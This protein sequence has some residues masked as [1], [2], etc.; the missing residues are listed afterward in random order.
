MCGFQP[1]SSENVLGLRNSVPGITTDASTH[2]IRDRR[3]IATRSRQ[4]EGSRCDSRQWHPCNLSVS[5]GLE[6]NLYISSLKKGLRGKAVAFHPRRIWALE[7]EGIFHFV[8]PLTLGLSRW[9]TVST[10]AIPSVSRVI[11]GAVPGHL[12]VF[13]LQGSG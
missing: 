4:F 11:P 10:E 2:E 6:L 3:F 5:G 9:D 12:G 8:Q 13:C 7:A 1:A